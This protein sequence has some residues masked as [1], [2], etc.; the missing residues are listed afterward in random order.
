MSLDCEYPN[1]CDCGCQDEPVRPGCKCCGREDR[2]ATDC[3]IPENARLRARIAEL[4]V[5]HL[6]GALG[7][8]QGEAD[9]LRA[10]RDRY[11]DAI[12]EWRDADGTDDVS[13]VFEA[14]SA[15]RRIAEVAK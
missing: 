8:A 5:L 10:E 15:L 11:R 4:T 13:R 7:E 2:H 14:E 6:S 1:S 3:L 12:V 9:A